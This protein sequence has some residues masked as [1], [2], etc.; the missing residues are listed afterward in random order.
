M[1]VSR[2][3]GR[4]MQIMVDG[5]QVEHVKQFQ[6]LGTWLTEDSRSSVDVKC[7]IAL[8]KVAFNSMK[9]LFTSRLQMPLKKRII[10]TVMGP[11]LL[12]S[13]ET[14]SLRKK[15]IQRLEACEMW[16]WRRVTKQV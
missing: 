4:T 14:W 12:Y 7:R 6:Y 5:E 11:V 16:I 8:A 1:V 15:E 10:K 3:I 9:E 13:C 2:D